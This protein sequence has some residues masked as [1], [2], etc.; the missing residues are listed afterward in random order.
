MYRPLYPGSEIQADLDPSWRSPC[1][2]RLDL[3]IDQIRADLD[4]GPAHLAVV[5][6]RP[7][8]QNHLDGAAFGAGQ[9]AVHVRHRPDVRVV[10]APRQQGRGMFSGAV[11]R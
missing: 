7:R 9:R 8:P 6:V 1:V 3:C 4:L 11:G 2:P 5:P 10:P